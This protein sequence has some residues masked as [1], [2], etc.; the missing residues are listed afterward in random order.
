MLTPNV[1][2]FSFHLLVTC[3]YLVFTCGYLVVTSGYL[4]ATTGYFWLLLVTSRYFSL[5]LLP[6]FSNNVVIRRCCSKLVFLKIFQTSQEKPVL[7]SFFNKVAGLKKS[8]TLLKRD[9]NTGLFL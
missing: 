3:G 1:F 8:A 6:R 2:D 4:I 9:S 7:E 5:L